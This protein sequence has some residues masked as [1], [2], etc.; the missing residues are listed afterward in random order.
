MNKMCFIG[1]KLNRQ[2]LTDGLLACLSD[3]KLPE[4]GPLPTYTPKYLVGDV[5]RVQVDGWCKATIVALFYREPL[6]PTGKY[7]TYQVRVKEGPD[8]GQLVFV[9]K[10]HKAYVRPMPSKYAT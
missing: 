7:A 4:P 8:A 10:D 5:V 3:G 2:E 6:W 9:P 1:K